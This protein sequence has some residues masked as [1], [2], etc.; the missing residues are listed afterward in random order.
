MIQIS[1][2]NRILLN[3]DEYTK[4]KLDLEGFVKDDV[5]FWTMEKAFPEM[6][7]FGQDAIFDNFG[8]YTNPNDVIEAV[9]EKYGCLFMEK[10]NGTCPPYSNLFYV[11]LKNVKDPYEEY[12]EY[13]D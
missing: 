10:K 3:G 7:L 4:V 5:E 1:Y 8:Y 11:Y 2:L 12:L 6:N 13:C 9:R